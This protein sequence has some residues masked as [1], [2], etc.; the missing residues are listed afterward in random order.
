MIFT[1]KESFSI[2]FG[3]DR[4]EAIAV[5]DTIEKELRERGVFHNRAEQKTKIIIKALYRYDTEE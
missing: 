5:A 2:P 3:N 4:E 1:K